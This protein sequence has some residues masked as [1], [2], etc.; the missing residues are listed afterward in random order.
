M[1]EPP[2]IGIT[3]SVVLVVEGRDE[4]LFFSAFAK[5]LGLTTLQVMGIG[6]KTKLR[7]N[8]KAL[9]DAPGFSSV[10]SLGIVRDANNDPRA[11]F[12]SVSD[13]LRDCGLSVPREVGQPA[14]RE[15]RVMAFIVPDAQRSGMLEDLCLAAVRDDPAMP[16]LDPFF[17][18]VEERTQLPAELSKAKVHAFLSSRPTP[19]LRLG[20]AA[21]KGYWPFENAAFETIKGFLRELCA[22]D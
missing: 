7:A 22:P 16:C 12:L 14:G 17:D 10:V 21:Q 18:C 19:D 3:A 15:P 20:E 9:R 1:P 6:G 13:A 5:R 4:E 11:A 8:L 2:R